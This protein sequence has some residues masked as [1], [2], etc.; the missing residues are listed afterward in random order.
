MSCGLHLDHLDAGHLLNLIIS[1]GVDPAGN[2]VQLKGCLL[3]VVAQYADQNLAKVTL[4]GAVRQSHDSVG[5]IVLLDP[6]SFELQSPEGIQFTDVPQRE[7][8]VKSAMRNVSTWRC[9]Y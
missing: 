6:P 7:C 3:M 1:F 2:V 5:N 9:A 4:P 8:D